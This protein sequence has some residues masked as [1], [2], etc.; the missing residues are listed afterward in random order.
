MP[1]VQGMLRDMT[2]GVALEEDMKCLFSWGP[3]TRH[4]HW[5]KGISCHF[6]W[7]RHFIQKTSKSIRKW[8]KNQSCWESG[9]KT[10]R[11]FHKNSQFE[12]QKLQCRFT[13]HLPASSLVVFCAAP[14]VLLHL[15]L[16]LS[17]PYWRCEASHLAPRC[18]VPRRWK[19]RHR[20]V[21]E[22]G[23]FHLDIPAR[24]LND[25]E[26]T[27]LLSHTHICQQIKPPNCWDWASKVTMKHKSAEQ[28]N[29]I[30]LNF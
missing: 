1:F 5:Q 30:Q 8:N 27:T 18:P 6:S 9:N 22:F 23:R 24:I 28:Q 29:K 19:T 16:L 14:S 10:F 2:I 12:L 13:N 15:G 11:W 7:F 21:T 4:H 17:A 25:G 3:S 26:V 20:R